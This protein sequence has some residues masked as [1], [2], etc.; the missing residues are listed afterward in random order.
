METKQSNSERMTLS[1]EEAAAKLGISRS[2]AYELVR[3]A[4]FPVTVIRCGRRLLVSRNALNM[5]LSGQNAGQ[6]K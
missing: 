3:E 2:L 1:V 6:N 4:K 5:L